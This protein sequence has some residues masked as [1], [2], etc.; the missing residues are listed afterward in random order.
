[1]KKERRKKIIWTKEQVQEAVNTSY[2]I[3][4][5]IRKLINKKERN[6]CDYRR[7][8]KCIEEFDIDLS[9]FPPVH[10]RTSIGSKKFAPKIDD[11]ILFTLW[12]KQLVQRSTIVNR[13][14]Q[15]HLPKQCEICDI[16][17]WCDYTLTL[18]LDH[19][20]G[21]TL[22]NRVENLRWLC[23]NCH[24]LTPT[25][26]NKKIIWPSFQELESM[27][28]TLTI[29]EIAKNIGTHPSNVSKRCTLQKS[30][31]NM[32]ILEKQNILL[33]YNI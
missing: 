23:P 17:K 6:S 22:D 21:N 16:I 31:Q 13:F 30:E 19:I 27:R 9:H 3:A 4:E 12:D 24:S 20:N 28:Q 26:I 2:S 25:Y 15:I 5:T 32:Q 14:T 18:Q 10:I 33:D 1:M 11:A 8:M 7:L 29:T